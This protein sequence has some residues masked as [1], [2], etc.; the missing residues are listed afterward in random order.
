ME[1]ACAQATEDVEEQVLQVAEEILDIV[2]E[3][4]QKE[5]VA[6]DMQP[7]GVQKHA[8][9][10]RKERSFEGGVAD[11]KRRKAR[12]DGAEGVGES[13]FRLGRE[14]QFVEEDE[15]VDDDKE[16]VDDGKSATGIEVLERNEHLSASG[17]RVTERI[18]N[19]KGSRAS[20]S[21][22][23]SVSYNV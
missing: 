5:H 17:R 19:E 20:E 8:G 21:C 2:S 13:G 9:E 12:R 23:V 11:E 14:S 1:Q 22:A 10:E 16:R 4:P 15:D 3:D 18:Q 6:G 7:A